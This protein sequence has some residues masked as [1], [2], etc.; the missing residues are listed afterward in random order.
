MIYI[1][2]FSLSIIISSYIN[3]NNNGISEETRKTNYTV[4]FLTM[5]FPFLVSAVR[6][7]VGTDYSFAYT[8]VFFDILN[9]ID[10]EGFKKRGPIFYLFMKLC[11]IVSK[12]YVIVFVITSFIICFFTVLSMYKYSSNIS[13]SIFLWLVSGSYFY[14]LS[15]VRQFVVVAILISVSEWIFTEKRKYIILCCFL[16]FVH[17][18]AI[19]GLLL[20]IFC[21]FNKIIYNKR[22]AIVLFLVVILINPFASLLINKVYL[23]LYQYGF[24]STGSIIASQNFSVLNFV[25]SL[26]LVLMW[27]LEVDISKYN[28]MTRVYVNVIFLYFIM[29][30]LSSN[31]PSAERFERFF[32]YYIFL[33]IPHFLA[34]I[35]DKYLQVLLLIGISVFLTCSS[36]YIHLYLGYDDVFPYR[37]IWDR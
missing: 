33:I 36:L 18:S 34:F 9:G 13:F 1:I 27:F 28:N 17:S 14:T 10:V 23:F 20:F 29:S 6:Y 35:K 32:S 2:S 24:V 5:L 22:Y 16:F 15:Q 37:T 3:K 25:Y 30:V 26:L 7:N 19:L 31:I 21:H 12:D 4:I 11:T 8:K